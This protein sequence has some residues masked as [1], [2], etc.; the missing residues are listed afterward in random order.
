L[1]DEKQT[2]I[3]GPGY[4]TTRVP[5]SASPSFT[6][7]P[8]KDPNHSTISPGPGKYMPPLKEHTANIVFGK[9]KAREDFF[10]KS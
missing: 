3:P 6:F 1:I 4:L 8:K 5:G 9:G 7:R 2:Y 10:N